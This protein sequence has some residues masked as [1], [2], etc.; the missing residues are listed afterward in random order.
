MCCLDSYAYPIVIPGPKDPDQ[1]FE[2]KEERHNANNMP[3][4]AE[5][6]VVKLQHLVEAHEF[7]P[8]PALS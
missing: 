4:C 8:I 6:S 3:E 1:N 2:K 5:V 7:F